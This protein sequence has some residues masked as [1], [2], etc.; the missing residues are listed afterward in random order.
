M[1]TTH[2]VG[3]SLFVCPFCERTFD[4]PESAC[5]SCGSTV[6]VPL[7]DRVAYED[8]LPMCGR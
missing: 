6:V 5:V 1:S 4:R 2:P 3:A 8:I 7:E